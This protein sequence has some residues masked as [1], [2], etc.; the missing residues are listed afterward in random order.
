MYWFS[1][2]FSA[3]ELKK[4]HKVAELFEYHQAVTF[5]NH[6]ENHKIRKSKIKWLGENYESTQWIYDKLME[7]AIIANSELLNFDLIS[8]H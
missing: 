4:V 1:E 5:G 7:F 2:G 3:D 8:I 6:G